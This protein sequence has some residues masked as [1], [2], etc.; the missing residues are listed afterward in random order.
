MPNRVRAKYFSETLT[1]CSHNEL[2]HVCIQLK[3]V[4]GPI[5]HHSQAEYCH[6]TCYRL[7]QRNGAQTMRRIQWNGAGPCEH[8][9]DQSEGNGAMRG[10]GTR[11]PAALLAA[12]RA[13]R[14]GHP[15]LRIEG[16]STSWKSYYFFA[17]LV[18]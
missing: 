18:C 9:S 16:R 10:E 8:A 6:S 4:V 17:V 5:R 2:F 15:H 3:V 12:R 11:T 13:N 7:V 14:G 1:S